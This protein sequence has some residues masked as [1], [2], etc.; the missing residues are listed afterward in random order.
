MNRSP[1]TH[2]PDDVVR[3]AAQ[4]VSDTRALWRQLDRLLER[5]ARQ[6]ALDDSDW[7][8]SPDGDIPDRVAEILSPREVDVTLA[9]MLARLD[10]VAP[11]P[12]S[13]TSEELASFGLA[14]PGYGAWV[15]DRVS[16]VLE[17]AAARVTIPAVRAQLADQVEQLRRA[18][19]PD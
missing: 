1:S 9:A 15:V 13:V 7:A 12:E 8:T 19:L 6:R 14:V 11:E 17:A 5:V 16:V 10:E 2:P 4:L 18:H 3:E